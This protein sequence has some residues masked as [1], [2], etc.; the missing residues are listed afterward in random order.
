MVL[1]GRRSPRTAWGAPSP[2]E[3]TGKLAESGTPSSSGRPVSDPKVSVV[4]PVR[5]GVPYLREAVESVLAQT[6]HRPRVGRIGELFVRRRR[7]RSLTGFDDPRLR[8]V[9][10]VRPLSIIENW[11]RAIEEPK[12]EWMTFLGHDD[13]F[14]PG[15]LD[16]MI[17]LIGAIP[18][19]T[20]F[21][22][23]F[24]V[25]D[26]A[27]NVR[28]THRYMPLRQSAD[29]LAVQAFRGEQF[30]TGTGYVVR[31]EQFRKGGGFRSSPGSSPLR[32]RLLVPDRGPRLACVR[33]QDL[34]RLPCPRCQH[35]PDAK[36]PGRL[37]RCPGVH[38]LLGAHRCPTR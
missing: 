35:A 22:S 5:N 30:I 4:L 25:I 2:I 14:Y 26:G 18:Q 34:G 16:E 33:S 31:T 23:H 37:R 15:F 7:R 32:R 1:S 8:V 12:G 20:V 17:A 3:R 38:R 29:D 9:P 13:I 36:L 10:A 24:D 6:L 19:A 28:R 11:A 27:G 21:H